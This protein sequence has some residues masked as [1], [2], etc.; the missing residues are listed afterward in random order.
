M[1]ANPTPTP[2]KNKPNRQKEGLQTR[3]KITMKLSPAFF[4]ALTTMAQASGITHSG[5][6]IRLCCST[7]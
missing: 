3:A 5:S 4:Q 7:A 6:R 2:K 1:E